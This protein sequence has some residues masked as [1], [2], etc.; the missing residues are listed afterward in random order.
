MCGSRVCMEGIQRTT[1]CTSINKLLQRLPF[2]DHYCTSI[3]I[4]KCCWTKLPMQSCTESHCNVYRFINCIVLCILGMTA[5]QELVYRWWLHIG[6]GFLTTWSSKFWIYNPARLTLNSRKER[7][8]YM[9]FLVRSGICHALNVC[10]H[11]CVYGCIN[12]LM[13]LLKANIQVCLA[14][15]W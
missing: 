11:A 5:A 13:I 14:N 8:Y 7:A 6:S 1:F 4:L 9:A 10:M 2:E 3:Y 15:V 12:F